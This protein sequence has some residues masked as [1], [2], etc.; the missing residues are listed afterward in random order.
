MPPSV[1]V[2]QASAEEG[3][4]GASD[5]EDAADQALLEG[6]DAESSGGMGHVHVGQGSGDDA[7]VIAEEQ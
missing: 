6:V 3:A 4:E 5:E 2:G 1:A 7:G